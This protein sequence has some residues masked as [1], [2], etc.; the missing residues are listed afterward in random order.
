MTSQFQ[1]EQEKFWAGPFGS[2]YITRNQ[3]I[4]PK[5]IH[6]F[7]KVLERTH[8]VKSAIEFG[9]NIGLNLAAIKSL[10]PDVQVA[11]VEVNVDAYNQ[12]KTIPGVQA[13]NESILNFKPTHKFDL[14]MYVGVLIHINPDYLKRAYEV[15][16][17]SSGKYVLVSEYYSPS[18]VALPYRGH[19]DK[20]F[21][22]D[23]AGEMMEQYP[24]LKLVDYGFLY[25][26]DPNFPQDDM[27]WFL[28]EKR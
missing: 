7:S 3:D 2:E 24:D 10:M 23:F 28:M 25:R 17:A 26:R 16:Y 18:P 1:T 20:L 5:K 9:C 6:F 11:G 15:A 22:R 8:G 12:M 27:T 4:L 14:S 13:F 19:S 21:K